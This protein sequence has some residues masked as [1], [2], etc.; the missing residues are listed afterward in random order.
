[1]K[2]NQGSFKPRQKW[3]DIYKEIIIW[4]VIYLYSKKFDLW[5]YNMLASISIFY[6]PTMGSKKTRTMVCTC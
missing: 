4:S 3:T 2:W 1:V 6:K 5:V